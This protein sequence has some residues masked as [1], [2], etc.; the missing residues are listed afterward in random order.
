VGLM[1]EVPQIYFENKIKTGFEILKLAQ[2]FKRATPTDHLP[3][4]AHRLNFFAILYIKS[5]NSKVKGEHFID[6]EN[7]PFTNQNLIFVNNDQIHAFKKCISNYKGYL[8]IFTDDF[9]R[10]L[11]SEAIN[12]VYNYHLYNPVVTI[13]KEIQNEIG[14]LVSQLWKEYNGTDIENEKQIL[15]SYLNILLYKILPLRKSKNKI[16]SNLYYNEFLQFQQLLKQHLLQERSVQFYANEFLIST[17]KLNTIC[18]TIVN[19]SAKAYITSLLIL[20]IKRQLANTTKTIKEICYNTGFDEP[21]NFVKFF[22]KNTNQA[23]LEFRNG[24]KS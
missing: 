3:F 18:H 12:Q 20:E 22:K 5:S 15:R 23:P 2:L 17:K 24:L 1:K 11:N 10:S 7:H 14:N 9:I 6:F 16:E 13:P 4:Q 8:I 21:T 19:K